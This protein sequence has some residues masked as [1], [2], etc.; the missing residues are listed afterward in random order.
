MSAKKNLTPTITEPILRDLVNM[1]QEAQA[2][3]RIEESGTSLP[4]PAPA[5]LDQDPGSGFN[6]DHTFMQE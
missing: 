3:L 6:P 1:D 5:E 2:M 4:K